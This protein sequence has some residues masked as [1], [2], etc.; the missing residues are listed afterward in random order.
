VAVH[1]DDPAKEGEE[2]QQHGEGHHQ[3]LE[4]GVH[5]GPEGAG[6]FLLGLRRRGAGLPLGGAGFLRLGGVRGAVGV[7]HGE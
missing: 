6:L 7:G 2:E 4:P 1:P 5:I 3:G